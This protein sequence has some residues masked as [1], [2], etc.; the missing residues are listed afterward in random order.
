MGVM[1]ASPFVR[2]GVVLQHGQAAHFA[3]PVDHRAVEQAPL[4]QVLHEG[5]T[6]LVDF[7][8][9]VGQGTADHAVVVP[10]LPVVQH[11]HKAHPALHQPPGNQAAGGVVAGVILIEPIQFPDGVRLA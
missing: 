8:A 5:R 2:A 6:G 10:R 3:A 9:T 4:F 11:L 7:A 1:V